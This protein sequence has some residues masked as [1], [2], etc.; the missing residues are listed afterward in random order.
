MSSFIPRGRPC[1]PEIPTA[2]GWR[3][4]PEIGR[5]GPGREAEHSDGRLCV[6]RSF[7]SPYIF[8]PPKSL[9]FHAAVRNGDS[10]LNCYS[11]ARRFPFGFGPRLQGLTVRP[12]V[13][14]ILSR[15][16]GNY[17]DSRKQG[18][19]QNGA[20]FRKNQRENNDLKRSPH[21]V[22]RTAQAEN[23]CFLLGRQFGNQGFPGA[24]DRYPVDVHGENP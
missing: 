19:D 12:S 18:T 14:S 2:S 13:A 22:S 17:G 10:A 7:A 21:K 6:F 16:A 9:H 5:R 1:W 20:D 11:A 15:N 3:T 8:K 4:L 24:A 23:T